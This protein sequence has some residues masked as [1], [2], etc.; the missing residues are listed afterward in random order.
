MEKRVLEIEKLKA[1][2]GETMSHEDIEK[3]LRQKTQSIENNTPI[4]EKEI[5]EDAE[6]IEEIEDNFDE[7]VEELESE[8][9]KSNDVEKIE[10][11]EESQEEEKA[12]EIEVEEEIDKEEE[13]Q[14]DEANEFDKKEELE[15]E[16]PVT[17][18]IQMEEISPEK[19]AQLN[20]RRIEEKNG[21]SSINIVIYI[22]SFLAILLMIFAGYLYMNKPTVKEVVVYKS[23]EP[24]ELIKEVVKEVVKEKIVPAKEIDDKLLKSYFNSNNYQIYK[25]YDFKVGQATFPNEC[26]QSLKEFLNKNQDSFKLEIT[27]VVSPDDIE[28]INKAKLGNASVKM[29]E[30]I[31]RGFSR[32]RVLETSFYI[33]DFIK[34]DVVLTPVNYYVTS[35]KLSKGVIIKAYYL[36]K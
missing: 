13:T 24:K 5:I 6:I 30:Y 28:L 21:K 12:E 16:E 9:S 4:E 32:E 20:K 10:D 23:S 14:K 35:K 8:T 2:L 7:K 29:R 31:V 17:F 27:A 15:E 11:I 3:K 36:E 25:C 22:F 18:E 34:D 26:K 1:A 33:K 19:L